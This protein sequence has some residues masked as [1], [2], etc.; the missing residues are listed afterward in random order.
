MTPG[1]HYGIANDAY[2]QGEGLSHSGLKRIRMQTP[3]HYHALATATDAPP[4]APTPQMFNGTL[5]HCALLEP[6]H[7]DLRY[8]IAPDVSKSSRLYKEFAQ[9]CMSSGMEPISQLQRDAAF[10][11]AEALRKLPQVAELL[12]HGQ[13]EVSAWWRDVATGVLCKCRPD[14]VSPVGLGKGVVLLDVK[15]ASDASPEGFSKSVANFGYHTQADWYCTGFELA[16][17]MQVHGMVF[18]VVESEFPHACSA[19]MLSDAALLRAREENRE[20]LNLY[21]RCAEAK[22][23]PGYP[24]EI[25][26]IELPRWA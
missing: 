13:P 3:F 2:H 21:A 22:Q 18:A 10:R 7:F 4:K 6:E 9:Q 23:W 5:T 14:W 19:Y 8:V 24:S 26:V 15:T 17:G 20:A 25:Q 16:S 1:V 12:A 11:Q